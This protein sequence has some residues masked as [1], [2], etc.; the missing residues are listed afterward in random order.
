MLLAHHRP[1]A[2]VGFWVLMALVSLALLPRINY[3]NSLYGLL[4]DEEP[5]VVSARSLE[6][7]V[8][9]A[10]S[11]GFIFE[12]ED[13]PVMLDVADSLLAPLAR[14]PEPWLAS[15]E[16]DNRAPY[17]YRKALLM[18]TSAELEMLVEASEQ[19]LLRQNPFYFDIEPDS[20]AN[21]S[22]ML[23]FT[24]VHAWLEHAIGLPPR[25][26]TTPDGSVLV[27]EAFAGPALRSQGE[28]AMLAMIEARL[29]SINTANGTRVELYSNLG[30]WQPSSQI[31][32]V[33]RIVLRGSQISM[34]AVVLLLGFYLRFLVR[35]RLH[36]LPGRKRWMFRLF[37]AI[38]ATL[39]LTLL[40]TMGMASASGWT[41]N[42][43]SVPLLGIMLGVNADY[44]IHLVS[45]R[46][47][48]YRPGAN[49]I[50]M[51]ARLSAK[52]GKG[53]AFSLWTTGFA[54]LGLIFSGFLGFQSFGGLF[55]MALTINYVLTFTLFMA[56]VNRIIARG[57]PAFSSET[58]TRHH[59]YVPVDE[60]PNAEASISGQRASNAG[61]EGAAASHQSA[62]T[63]PGLT[64][65]TAQARNSTDTRSPGVGRHYPTTARIRWQ[66]VF[67]LLVLAG[68]LWSASQ[69]TFTYSLVDLEPRHQLSDA[70]A[71]RYSQAVNFL[72]AVEPSV[73]L[74][75]DL[76]T[77][78]LALQEIESQRDSG[79]A[80]T[81]IHRIESLV[82]RI[83][84]NS[85]ELAE[86]LTLIRALE[87]VWTDDAGALRFATDWPAAEQEIL[88]QSLRVDDGIV[89]D[90]LPYRFR[91]LL[92]DSS[93]NPLN[94]IALYP[95][96]PILDTP[97][98]LEFRADASRLVMEDGTEY[99]FVSTYL[100]SSQVLA[101]LRDEI[102]AILG[103]AILG[104]FIGT[105]MAFGQL[106]TALWTSLA[107]LGGFALTFA[108]LQPFGFQLHLY[109]VVAMPLLIGIGIDST[110]HLMHAAEYALQRGQS[111]REVSRT[112]MLYVFAA[113]LTTAM[114]FFGF[115]WIDYPGIQDLALLAVSGTVC[116]LLFSTASV[117][118]WFVVQQHRRKRV[119]S[120]PV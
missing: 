95:D 2:V 19:E 31:A 25:Y 42:L 33:N 78:R 8:Q 80:F 1:V 41:L 97:D 108:L 61:A 49:P 84:A 107:T 24:S 6:G 104:M 105:W 7:R 21:L 120:S 103:L 47:E 98:A 58:E 4:S 113:S 54:M 56:W 17:L 88:R 85:N 14:G 38:I 15:I 67:L 70:F 73:L 50:M 89:T 10:M 27:A 30:N 44:L 51:I 29:D 77:A 115:L 83:P 40:V 65:Q 99:H 48:L 87:N 34:L 53:M 81:R 52:T 119:D 66:L 100:L 117:Y 111:W 92:Y 118:T 5:L 20:S 64:L 23:Q 36:A 16:L 11:L 32:A 13:F 59:S 112:T 69:V 9:S 101:L 46:L 35:Q 96:N 71:S 116:I 28:Q 76:E 102:P 22:E 74:L 90:S 75:P 68:S 3:D 82:H 86:R 37:G 91:Q 109:N 94:L 63:E 93:G 39:F 12:G 60:I 114:G 57:T 106:S 110:I 26:R 55:L 43:F 72:D 79:Q 18:L 45:S 62:E